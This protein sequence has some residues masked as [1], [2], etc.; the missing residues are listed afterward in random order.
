MAKATTKTGAKTKT[1]TTPATR[2]KPGRKVMPSTSYD[3]EI[4]DWKVGYSFAAGEG[5]DFT[6]GPYVEHLRLEL[7]A[8]L[9]SP[10]KHAGKLV[11]IA[12]LGEREIDVLMDEDDPRVGSAKNVGHLRIHGDH[13]SYLGSMPA[14]AMWGLVP[15]LET[16]RVK[17]IHMTGDPL[18]HGSAD[19]R[20]ISF[21]RVLEEE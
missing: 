3:F 19:I 17:V 1:E 15:A 8:R 5:R 2:R 21:D 11:T 12:L 9:R 14:T 10:E 7:V 16:K 18:D 20:W 4:E 13:S 6:R